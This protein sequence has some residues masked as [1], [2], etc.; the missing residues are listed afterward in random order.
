MHPFGLVSYYHNFRLHLSLDRN[1]PTPR[2]VEP[3]S[4]GEVISIPQV[5]GLHHRYR[6]DTNGTVAW[7]VRGY[8]ELPASSSALHVASGAEA[9]KVVKLLTAKGAVLEKK[10]AAGATPLY[11][12]CQYGRENVVRTLLDAGANP[13]ASNNRGASV[14]L[15]ACRQGSLR[16]VKALLKKKADVNAKRKDGVTPLHMAAFDGRFAIAEALLAGGANVNAQTKTGR[17][18]LYYAEKKRHARVAEIL[19]K[20]MNPAELAL[21][22]ISVHEAAL[23]AFLL[24]TIQLVNRGPSGRLHGL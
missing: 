23:S 13:N 3:T 21:Q 7:G 14:L 17:T 9:A 2:E 5:G 22:G 6:C 10:Q 4:Q 11:F 8:A 15:I 20:A 19:K 24:L 1:S 12:A 16:N 18:P